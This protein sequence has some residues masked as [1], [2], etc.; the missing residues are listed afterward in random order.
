MVGTNTLDTAKIVKTKIIMEAVVKRE[1]T[2]VIT[3][4]VLT[5]TA[6]ITPTPTTTTT[7][8]ITITKTRTIRRTNTQ[9]P[10]VDLTVIPATPSGYCS[11]YID[12]NSMNSSN[13]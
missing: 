7:M 12:R 9:I 10:L 2:G 11:E 3:A 4:T 6:I 13:K 8:V 5:S 1:T